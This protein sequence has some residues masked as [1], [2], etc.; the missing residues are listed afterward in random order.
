MRGREA[1]GNLTGNLVDGLPLHVAALGNALVGRQPAQ[2]NEGL[3]NA[4]CRL[5]LGKA[6]AIGSALAA[7]FERNIFMA[8]RDEPNGHHHDDDCNHDHRA[9]FK[10]GSWSPGSILGAAYVRTSAS[11]TTN[12]LKIKEK[13][14][15]LF[16]SVGAERIKRRQLFRRR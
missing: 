14:A 16:P 1:D 3:P 2:T 9:I 6:H 12:D 4:D 10:H 8:L 15:E 7:E 13:M 11:S 5:C